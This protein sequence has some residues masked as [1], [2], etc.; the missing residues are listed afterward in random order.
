MKTISTTIIAVKKGNK[1]TMAGDGQ[2][3]LG[4]QIM[5]ASAKKVR[6]LANGK[7]VAGFA[8]SAADG[9]A[10]LERLEGK[11][12]KYGGNLTRAAVELAK[13][14]RMDKYLRRLE[15][16]L[17]VSDGINIYLISGNGDIIEPDLN[18]ITIGSGGGF[19]LAAAKMLLKHTD[20]NGREICEEALI[21]A[22]EIGIYTNN[23]ITIFE[24]EGER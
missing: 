7:I 19:A 16:V 3:T 10:L 1:V 24:V 18:V 20:K 14:W 5:K 4:N 15:A 12:E 2:V 11:L 13:D 22:S 8:G 21:T 9:I 17:L 6:T 23:N